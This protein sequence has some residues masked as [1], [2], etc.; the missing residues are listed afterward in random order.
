[1]VFFP[2]I[3][4]K[5]SWNCILTVQRII[6]RGKR[7]LKTPKKVYLFLRLEANRFWTFGKT[8][9]IK[10]SKLLFMC[11]NK[12]FVAKSLIIRSKIREKYSGISGRKQ[13]LHSVFSKTAL[14]V[15]RESLTELLSDFFFS[16]SAGFPNWT[17]ALRRKSSR[18]IHFMRK[19]FRFTVSGRWPNCI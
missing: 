13:D 15:W 12:R 14:T 7:L 3:Y 2:V 17:L 5:T 9:S 11:P 10:L 1:M 8:F 16:F 6:F 18:K 19:V 4:R